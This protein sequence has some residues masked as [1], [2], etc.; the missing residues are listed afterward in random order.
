[1][2]E[3]VI[4]GKILFS[5]AFKTC[6]LMTRQF[7]D[8]PIKSLLTPFFYFN[9]TLLYDY[10]I[11]T[12]HILVSEKFTAIFVFEQCLAT[13]PKQRKNKSALKRKGDIL[14]SHAALSHMEIHHFW[15]KYIYRSVWFPKETQQ[16]S[17][18]HFYLF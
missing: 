13:I 16:H 7:F 2:K 18:L 6:C 12:Q 15:S 11:T 4:L 3:K 14:H 10:K 1:M 17:V 5:L 8:R 9:I